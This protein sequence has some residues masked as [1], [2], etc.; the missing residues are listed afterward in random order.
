MTESAMLAVAEKDYPSLEAR[1]KKFDADLTE[2]M[3]K[4]GGSDYA[5][6]ASLV[7]RQTLAAH[8]LVADVDA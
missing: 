6:L 7:F 5:Y 4:V 3:Q 2:D 8:K 1:G